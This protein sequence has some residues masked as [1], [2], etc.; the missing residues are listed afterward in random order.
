[1]VAKSRQDSST[2]RLLT[3]FAA[4][5]LT[6]GSLLGP[7][8]W[9][10]GGEEF[11]TP[12]SV[13]TRNEAEYSRTARPPGRQVESVLTNPRGALTDSQDTGWLLHSGTHQHDT[14]ERPDA[15]SGLRMFCVAW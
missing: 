12:M 11:N 7:A 15:T 4:L 8:A 10:A 14:C 9:A 3:G 2:M 13:G 1:L 6:A 5:V